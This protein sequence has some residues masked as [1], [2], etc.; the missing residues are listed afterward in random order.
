MMQPP[1]SHKP[2]DYTKLADLSD[3]RN[4]LTNIREDIEVAIEQIDKADLQRNDV[5]HMRT[6]MILSGLEIKMT[7]FAAAMR[8][9]FLR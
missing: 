4:A 3:L 2:F 1:G 6:V 9:K 7:N 5:Q 8:A